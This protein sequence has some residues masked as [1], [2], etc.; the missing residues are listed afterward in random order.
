MCFVRPI[1]KK[2][3]GKSETVNSNVDALI[4]EKAVVVEKIMPLKPGLIKV[5]SEIWRAE[6]NVEIEVGEIVNIKYIRGTTAVVER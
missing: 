6:S 1:F 4:G 2:V 5:L 3:I